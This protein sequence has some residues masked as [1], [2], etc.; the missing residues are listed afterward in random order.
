MLKK[1]VTRIVKTEIELNEINKLTG[2]FSRRMKERSIELER[3]GY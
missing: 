2:A 3:R 1:E